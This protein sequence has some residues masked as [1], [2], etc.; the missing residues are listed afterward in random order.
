VDDALGAPEVFAVLFDLVHQ[1]RAVEPSTSVVL[2]ADLP[3]P[4][5]ALETRASQDVTCR[6]AIEQ[7]KEQLPSLRSL[8]E[9]DSRQEAPRVGVSSLKM[10]DV[11]EQVW[12]RFD[13]TEVVGITSLTS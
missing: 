8:L 1:H 9:Y 2:N 13:D 5:D 6:G 11:L 10:L 12:M 7:P 4:Q 3:P